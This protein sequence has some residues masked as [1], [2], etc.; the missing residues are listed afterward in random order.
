MDCV[1]QLQRLKMLYS[2]NCNSCAQ[3][4][5][6]STLVALKQL[7]SS[8]V[9]GRQRIMTSLSNVMTLVSTGLQCT[10]AG[11][12]SMTKLCLHFSSVNR[13]NNSKGVTGTFPYILL[14]V[15][16]QS[17]LLC[18]HHYDFWGI[19]CR[20][21]SVQPPQGRSSDLFTSCFPAPPT[22]PVM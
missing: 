18:I 14:L 2:W 1:K 17:V 3:A 19:A 13:Y 5:F 10:P 7:Q 12:L 11:C 4:P 9:S 22:M 16:G 20:P 8:P 21:P 6:S 15:A